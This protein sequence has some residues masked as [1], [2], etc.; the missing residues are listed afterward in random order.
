MNNRDD[1]I[2]SIIHN[3]TTDSNGNQIIPLDN[4]KERLE[5][6][7]CARSWA[8]MAFLQPEEGILLDLYSVLYT[9]ENL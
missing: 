5:D 9:E 1:F 7:L 6:E 2:L 3:M 8:G 4:L